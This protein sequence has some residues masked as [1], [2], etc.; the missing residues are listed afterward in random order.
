MQ[1]EI[2][3]TSMLPRQAQPC[4]FLVSNKAAFPIFCFTGRI[5]CIFWQTS[6][7]VTNTILQQRFAVV[8]RGRTVFQKKKISSVFKTIR[9][10]NPYVGKFLLQSFRYLKK[11]KCDFNWI[12]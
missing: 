6:S 11:A 1:G 2:R 9:N 12:M 3:M 5:Y 8:A 7:K 4:W 10:S